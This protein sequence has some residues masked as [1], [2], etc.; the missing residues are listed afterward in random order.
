MTN[1]S[2][3]MMTGQILGGSPVIEAARYQILIIWLIATVSFSTVLMNAFVVYNVSFETGKHM[4]R[5]ERFIEVVKN[6]KKKGWIV[7]SYM[8]KLHGTIRAVCFGLKLL[9]C[10]GRGHQNKN[11]EGFT[12][13]EQQPL[14]NQS[15]SYGAGEKCKLEICTTTQNSVHSA[16]PLI[17][18]S[19]LQFSVPKM[20]TKKDARAR[21]TSSSS[22]PA[23]SQAEQNQRI[24]CEDLDFKLCAGELGLV[25][26]PSGSGKSTLLR[27]MAGLSHLDKGDIIADGMSLSKCEMTCWRSMVRYVTQ[28]KVDI[29]G[30]ECSVFYAN[31]SVHLKSSTDAFI[32][33][34]SS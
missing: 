15:S 17:Q 3:G 29:P 26:G 20:H 2:I 4:L 6:K 14:S 13:L 28:Y 24:L 1:S 22:L 8:S 11:K 30:S 5:T 32:A 16:Q 27:V 33:L 34:S 19:K 21:N 10:C 18:V 12:D 23:F 25:R 9:I 31:I 7:K